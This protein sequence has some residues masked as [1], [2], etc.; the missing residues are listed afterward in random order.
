MHIRH[1]CQSQSCQENVSLDFIKNGVIVQDT[2]I[3]NNDISV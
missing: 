2:L 1:F 3:F